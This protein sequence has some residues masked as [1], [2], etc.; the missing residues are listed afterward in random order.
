[1]PDTLLALTIEDAPLTSPEALALIL[2]LNAELEARYPEPGANFFRL[3]PDEVGPGRGAFV[4]ARED[5]GAAIACGAVR[6]LGELVPGGPR[7]AE[8]KRMF[9]EPARRGH[10]IAARVLEALEQRARS[11]GVQ[12]LVLE[13]GARQTEAVALYA[14][15]G[16]VPI[17]RFGEY[18][19]SELSVCMGKEL[20]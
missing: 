20:R 13:T 5:T 12:R 4:L 8:V 14:R 2:R 6:V 10:R 16:F 18:V 11:L 9:V 17:E 19:T 7:T 15:A 1:M 3:D